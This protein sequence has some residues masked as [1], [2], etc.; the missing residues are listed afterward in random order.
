[1][2]LARELVQPLPAL[3]SDGPPLPTIS[4]QH[5]VH[6]ATVG[7]MRARLK[8]GVV[9]AAAVSASSLA[10][11]AN[12][13]RSVI[14]TLMLA[15]VAATALELRP[16]THCAARSGGCAMPSMGPPVLA[17]LLRDLLNP[18]CC[19]DRQVMCRRSSDGEE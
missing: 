15:A 11:A 14:S 3:T 6:S 7:Q 12:S 19:D 1:M 16:L 18:I 13:D 9:T 10:S 4:V 5:T 17:L 2:A 8:Y